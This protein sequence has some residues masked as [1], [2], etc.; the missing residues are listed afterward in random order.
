MIETL[1]DIG[2]WVV[3][4]IFAWIGLTMIV[5]G[6][7]GFQPGYTA[8]HPAAAIAIHWLMG[9]LLLYAAWRFATL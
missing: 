4:V 2:C 8:R 3:A 7:F 5:L 1:L 9:G 6:L